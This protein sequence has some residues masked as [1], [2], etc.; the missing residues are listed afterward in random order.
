MGKIP[1][2]RKW[3]PTPVFLPG[4]SCGWRILA[5]YS[6]CSHIESDM[7]EHAGI[8]CY[9][10]A[11]VCML[12]RVWLFATPWT[13]IH[14]ALLSMGILQARILHC[15][16]LHQGDLP[17]PGIEPRSSALQ[18]DSLPSESPRKSVIE[19]EI[20]HT[21]WLFILCSLCY[22]SGKVCGVVLP[23]F[24][25]NIISLFKSTKEDSN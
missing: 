10:F 23:R 14:Q 1:W 9:V 7:T 18:E 3:Q 21:L 13:V 15:H 4:K 22:H 20:K 2:R 24:H 6:P 5:G 16:A 12:S 8:S 17:N 19:K 11:C 25:F